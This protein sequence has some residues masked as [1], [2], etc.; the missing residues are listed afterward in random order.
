MAPSNRPFLHSLGLYLNDITPQAIG[1]R[2]KNSLNHV[3]GFLW[4]YVCIHY[5]QKNTLVY[6]LLLVKLNSQARNP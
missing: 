1:T 2:Q 4:V 5:L 6:F 3:L